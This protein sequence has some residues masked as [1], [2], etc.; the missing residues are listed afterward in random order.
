MQIRALGGL[1]VEGVGRRSKGLVP[2]QSLVT[3]VAGDM[4]V[5]AMLKGT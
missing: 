5:T 2:G 3:S 1:G 4:V